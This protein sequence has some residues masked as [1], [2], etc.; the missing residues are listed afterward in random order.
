MPCEPQQET[1]I[2]PVAQQCIQNCRMQCT[3]LRQDLRGLLQYLLVKPQAT[4]LEIP[5][6][7]GLSGQRYLQRLPV[8]VSPVLK[9]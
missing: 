8:Q 9:Q 5:F 4:L 6:Q 1:M 7:K 3:T 2:P